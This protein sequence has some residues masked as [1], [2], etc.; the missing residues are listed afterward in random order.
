MSHR[1]V[2]RQQDREVRM[3]D[4]SPTLAPHLNGAPAP[5]VAVNG[6][7]HS[8]HASPSV[9]H[10]VA[11]NGSAVPLSLTQKLTR[12]NEDIWMLVGACHTSHLLWLCL[13]PMQGV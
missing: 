9:A 2:S 5:V 4:P 10:A 8:H 7:H 12:A 11:V 1:H 13:T 6:A 3:A